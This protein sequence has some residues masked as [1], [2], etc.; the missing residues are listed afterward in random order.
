MDFQFTYYQGNV[1]AKCSMEHF[2]VAN[3]FNAEIPNNSQL[4]FTA[5]SLIQ[6]AKSFT[7][8]QETQLIGKEYSLFI[9]GEEVMIRANNLSINHEN[10]ELE[11]DFHYYDEESMAF[12]GLEDFERFLT[13][14]LEF[15]R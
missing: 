1:I 15:M 6:Q 4:I 11:Q 12:L 9:N 14:Y 7:A 13:S 2:A 5:L 10:E 3:W 8:E